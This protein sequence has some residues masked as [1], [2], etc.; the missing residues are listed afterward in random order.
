[1][2]LGFAF[3]VTGLLSVAISLLW[4]HPG[5]H[6]VA[7]VTLASTGG[8]GLAVTLLPTTRS[9]RW[10]RAGDL[11][12]SVAMLALLPLLV[13]ATGLYAVVRG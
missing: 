7:A 11:A 6:P 9:A 2:I 3:G 5:W 4:L 1:M 13:V 12:E 10:E 8:V